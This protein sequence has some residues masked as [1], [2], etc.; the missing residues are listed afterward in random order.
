MITT[1][2]PFRCRPKC[3]YSFERRLLKPRQWNEGNGET[4]MELPWGC[5]MVQ[6]T[7]S[8]QMAVRK[9]IVFIRECRGPNKQKYPL[10]RPKNTPTCPSPPDETIS[11]RRDSSTPPFCHCDCRHGMTEL[12]CE[13]FPNNS[14]LTVNAISAGEGNRWMISHRPGSRTNSRIDVNESD[15]SLCNCLERE[16][17]YFR[18]HPGFCPNTVRSRLKQLNE[19]ISWMCFKGR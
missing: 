17:Q 8:Q 18:M 4:W 9:S 3:K 7:R 6:W 15:E 14:R 10:D 1:K 19:A 12:H 5:F 2:L 13:A 11:R 16:C